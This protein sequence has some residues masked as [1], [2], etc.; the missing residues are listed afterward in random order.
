MA[1]TR[2]RAGDNPPIAVVREG[3]GPEVLL[4]H[5]GASPQTTWSGLEHLSRRWTLAFPYRRGY[6]PSPPPPDGRQDFEGDAADLEPLLDRRPH[7]VGHSYG[8]V[9]A[10]L[11]A[12]R[13]PARVRS[14]TLIEPALFLPPDDPEVARFARLGDEF[15]ANGL[16]TEPTRLR[17]FLTISGA[18]VPAEGP[19]PEDVVRGVRRAQG[20]RPPSEAHPPLEILREAGIPS[21]VA[22]GNH[23]PA[24]ERMCDAVAAALA[25][26]RLICPGA[27]HFVAAAPGFADQLEQFLDSVEHRAVA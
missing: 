13:R 18:P 19:L 1:R 17:E 21:L 9:S 16:A 27:G 8:G 15:L 20:S 23:H 26:Q 4:V 10:A 3:T 25:A 12:I 24:I 11:A 7:L 14:L 22:S 6:E 5:G 2:P